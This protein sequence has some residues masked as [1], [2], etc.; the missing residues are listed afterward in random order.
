MRTFVGSSGRIGRDR[1][2][3]RT[4]LLDDYDYLIACGRL[5]DCFSSKQRAVIERP[6]EPAPIR[7]R[8]CPCLT[9]RTLMHSATIAPEFCAISQPSA[10]SLA[11]L[12]RCL[13]SRTSITVCRSERRAVRARRCVVRAIQNAPSL[14]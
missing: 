3:Y 9:L 4:G 7:A 10:V 1:G 2:G 11:G 8:A 5:S 14:P 12:L 6:S 13:Q